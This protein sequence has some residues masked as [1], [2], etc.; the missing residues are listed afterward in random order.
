MSVYM[1]FLIYL[2]IYLY[3]DASSVSFSFVES[4]QR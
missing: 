4:G 1:Y 2:S 3:I